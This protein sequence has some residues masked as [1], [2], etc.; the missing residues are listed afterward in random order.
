[1]SHSAQRVAELQAEYGSPDLAV[2]HLLCDRHP[3]D[4]VAATLVDPDLETVDLTY[5]ELR[6]RS[7]RLAAGLA[8]LGVGPGSRVAALLPKTVELPV[9]LL[10]IWRLGAV[11]VPLFTAFAPQAIALRLLASGASVVIAD[12]G[13]RPKLDPGEDMPSDPPWTIVTVGEPAAGDVR[14]DDLAATPASDAVPVAVGADGPMVQLY[15]SGTTGRPK[16]VVVPARALASMVAYQEFGLDV[17]PDDVFWNGADPGWAYG[18]YYALIAPLATGRCTV[19]LNAGFSARLTWDVLANLGVTNVASAPTVYRALRSSG[20]AAPAGLALRRC[21]SAGEPLN[22][23]IVTWAQDALG[24][25]VRDHYGQTELGMVVING[26]HPDLEA[27]IRPGSMGRPM[28]GFTIGVLAEDSD[29]PAAPGSLGRVAVNIADS[30]LMWFSG[31]DG[32][33]AT[34]A[35]KFTADGRWYLTGDAGQVDDDGYLFF[36]SRDDDVIIM[37]GYRIGP[38]DIESVLSAHPAVAETAVVGVPDAARGEVV[39]AFVVLRAGFEPADALAVELATLVKT[40]YAAHA[41]P[42]RVHFTD[43]LP[44]TPSGKIQRFVLRAQRR[45]E[46]GRGI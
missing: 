6:E 34:S 41:Y 16:G 4:A 27:P 44:K 18:L 2:A 14:F 46:L 38:F 43:E 24:V 8:T 28:P 32:D 25:P 26:W 35:E 13:Q 36:S 42:R 1:M 33:P 19:L 3:A 9:T 11:Y 15:T 29:E 7:E 5:G 31:Y 45:E 17:S 39:E 23:D 37:A 22:P 40:R 30:P 21:S 10:A 20:I 12:A